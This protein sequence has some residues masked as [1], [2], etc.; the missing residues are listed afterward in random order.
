M[1]APPHA[2][3]LQG[4]NQLTGLA[5]DIAVGE[6]L[7]T[8]MNAWLVLETVECRDDQVG[9]QRLIVQCRHDRSSLIGGSCFGGHAEMR[10]PRN[11]PDDPTLSHRHLMF[12]VGS[13]GLDPN[14]IATAV[15]PAAQ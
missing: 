2:P 7:I 8:Q 4:L 12:N 3:L 13:A 10:H 1:G 15:R 6:N 11:Q 5:T 14:E 9:Q